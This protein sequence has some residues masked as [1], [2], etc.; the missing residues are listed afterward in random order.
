MTHTQDAAADRDRIVMEP[1]VV[2]FTD[3]ASCAFDKVVLRENGILEAT[4]TRAI[5]DPQDPNVSIRRTA[6]IFYNAQAWT[7]ARAAPVGA[8][9]AC[10]RPRGGERYDELIASEIGIHDIPERIQGWLADAFPRTAPEIGSAE[11]QDPRKVLRQQFVYYDG[12]CG[13][14]AGTVEFVYLTADESDIPGSAAG[15]V[16]ANNFSLGRHFN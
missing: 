13:T 10:I 11:R 2:T 4:F 1:A 9:K 16:D 15:I 14:A 6:V 3:N 8:L 7:A 12:R 5:T